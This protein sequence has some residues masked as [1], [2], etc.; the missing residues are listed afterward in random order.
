MRKVNQAKLALR[1]LIAALAAIGVCFLV[2]P[3]LG[4]GWQVL[5]GNSISYAG[6]RIPLPK[7]YYM[8]QER[9]GPAIWRLSLGAPAFDVPYGHFS[10]YSLGSPKPLFSA[11]RD[12]RLFEETM[13][14]EAVESGH[15]LESRQT[16]SI[17]DKS[18]Y[19]LEFIRETK[20]PR[21]L[22]RCAVE[23]SNFYVFYEGDP[24]Y[25]PGLRSLLQG[26]SP[27]KPGKDGAAKK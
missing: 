2:V 8:T 12:Y 26:M 17:G 25:L 23:N 20:Q 22:A 18:A 9:K 5:H 21:S 24:R 16:L 15:H 13:V 6:W 10:F 11:A 14:K 19:C 27:E 3:L 7:G 4:F 1:L